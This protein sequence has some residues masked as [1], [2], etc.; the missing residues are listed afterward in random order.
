MIKVAQWAALSALPLH[1]FSLWS[2][3][4][5]LVCDMA[6]TSTRGCRF[7]C[8]GPFAWSAAVCARIIRWECNSSKL[9]RHAPLPPSGAIATPSEIM[10]ITVFQRTPVRAYHTVQRLGCSVKEMG[11]TSRRNTTTRLLTAVVC[12]R[13]SIYMKLA[14]P[15]A[16]AISD[17]APVF[18]VVVRTV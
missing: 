1:T 6:S 14:D 9:H 13:N 4:Q 15:N 8:N 12:W 16:D 7:S 2:T 18:V 11:E 3:P 17:G 10:D 5:S